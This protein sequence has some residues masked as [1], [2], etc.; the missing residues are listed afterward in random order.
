MTL[1]LSHILD[2]DMQWMQDILKFNNNSLSQMTS[3][4]WNTQTRN[5]IVIMTPDI[6]IISYNI[7]K[8]IYVDNN[9]SANIR[10]RIV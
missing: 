2:K 1:S 8:N 10:Q 3:M 7:R 5:L 4:H 6:G 9:M